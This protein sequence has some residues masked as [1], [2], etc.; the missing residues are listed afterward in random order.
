MKK[1]LITVPTLVVLVLTTGCAST[2][3]EAEPNTQTMIPIYVAGR[4][5]GS[6]QL[7]NIRNTENIE[8]Y[9]IG[10]YVDPNN[11]G[12]MYEKNVLYRV[13]DNA[14]WNTRP[15]P[16][17]KLSRGTNVII[18][19][20]LNP[21]YVK[22]LYAE[23]EN[24]VIEMKDANTKYTKNYAKMI[25]KGAEKIELTSEKMNMVIDQNKELL[26]QQQKLNA[27][28]A[29]MQKNYDL[30]KT[31]MDAQEKDNQSISTLDQYNKS[32][33]NAEDRDL[34]YSN[35]KISFEAMNDL[36]PGNNKQV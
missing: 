27:K 11:N 32:E 20:N 19:E 15:N 2:P 5:I 26:F 8:A 14:S 23:L 29:E 22:P 30:L 7:H 3:P 21:A 17:V 28:I 18:P 35:D 12:I 25:Q 6:N 4:T 1:L 34:E 9:S 31:K 24:R 13:K 10:R 36:V 16:P 33:T